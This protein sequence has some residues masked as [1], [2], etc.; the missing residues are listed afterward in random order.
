ML[1]YVLDVI[2]VRVCASFGANVDKFNVVNREKMD[3]KIIAF[4]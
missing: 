3:K 2:N 1:E 4:I